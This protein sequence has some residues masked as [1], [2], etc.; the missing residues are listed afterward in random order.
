MKSLTTP[1]ESHGILLA[2]KISKSLVVN[3]KTFHLCCEKV[4]KQKP[5][6]LVDR[7]DDFSF[8]L[9]RFLRGSNRLSVV[10]RSKVST[11]ARGARLGRNR[12]SLTFDKGKKWSQKVV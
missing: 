10:G 11:A 7:S 3:V 6:N 2:F 8:F 1:T 5:R 12:I 9:F 4:Q